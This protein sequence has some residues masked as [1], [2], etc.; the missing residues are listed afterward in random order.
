MYDQSLTMKIFDLDAEIVPSV[1]APAY[2]TL[3]DVS[4]APAYLVTGYTLIRRSCPQPYPQLPSTAVLMDKIPS[5]WRLQLPFTV[6]AAVV[7]LFASIAQSQGNRE[8]RQLL[9]FDVLQKGGMWWLAG[10]PLVPLLAGVLIQKNSGTLKRE[11]QLCPD[12]ERERPHKKGRATPEFNRASEIR[13]YVRN[14]ATRLVQMGILRGVDDLRCLPDEYWKF[15]DAQPIPGKKKR[16]PEFLADTSAAVRFAEKYFQPQMWVLG[17]CPIGMNVAHVCSLLKEPIS[18]FSPRDSNGVGK[19]TAETLINRFFGAPNHSRSISRAHH[20]RPTLCARLTQPDAEL[21]QCIEQYRNISARFSAAAPS[22][23]R[24]F[25]CCM[26][27]M[28]KKHWLDFCN[29]HQL[30]IEDG[31]TAQSSGMWGWLH[32]DTWLHLSQAPCPA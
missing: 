8:S 15:R 4:L 3:I 28:D 18:Q 11:R 10:C 5:V 32:R 6:M 14:C 22:E 1:L 13:I 12:N 26:S 30:E 21:L 7:A 25:L 9:G 20:A 31:E 29:Q 23:E 24:K 19:H 17:K 27:G 2:F 16:S